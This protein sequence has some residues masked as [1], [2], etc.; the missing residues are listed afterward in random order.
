MQRTTQGSTINTFTIFC[1]SIIISL[2][3]VSV[4]QEIYKYIIHITKNLEDGW[5][6]EQ[7]TGVC[8]DK[9][10]KGGGRSHT[11]RP[12]HPPSF[13]STTGAAAPLQAQGFGFFFKGFIANH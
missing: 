7:G 11:L 6:K 5:T 1:E 9:R 12:P 4:S 8:G 10:I 3:L 2:K 13:L